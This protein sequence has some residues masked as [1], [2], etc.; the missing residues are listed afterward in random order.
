VKLVFL[1][2]PCIL[3]C[4]IEACRW[5]PYAP[6]DGF[7][8]RGGASGN[9]GTVGVFER[10]FGCPDVVRALPRT[11]EGSRE[12]DGGKGVVPKPVKSRP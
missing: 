7:L 3:P 10:E 2:C 12:A 4:T 9:R 5:C 11:W 6:D 1:A 8:S